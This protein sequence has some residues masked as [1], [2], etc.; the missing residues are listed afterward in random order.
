MRAEPPG[1]VR[2]VAVNY[3]D[4]VGQSGPINLLERPLKPGRISLA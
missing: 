2:L 1:R 4:N 3:E